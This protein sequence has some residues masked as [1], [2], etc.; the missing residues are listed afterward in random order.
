[1]L[2]L[3]LGLHAAVLI[4][5]QPRTVRVAMPETVID[6]RLVAPAPV[7]A[8]SP[9]P[10][11][12]PAR[13]PAVKPK[14]MLAKHPAPAV[15]PTPAPVIK[16]VPLPR[17]PAP[18][19]SSLATQA[20]VTEAPAQDAFPATTQPAVPAAKAD[21]AWYGARQ[22]DVQPRT[23]QPVEPVYPPEARRRN[24]EGSV[25]LKLRIDEFGN[26]KDVEVV[27]G[28]PPGVFDQSA[29]DAFQKAHFEPAIK[30]GRPV[31]ALVFIRVRYKL[32]DD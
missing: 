17:V 3:S 21:P 11:P 27:Q 20:P 28:V 14:P 9:T 10:A 6:A 24:Q 1:M 4:L 30:D 16:P 29:L 31:R 15:E 18:P 7:P 2:L 32:N 19:P 8:T 23:S 13:P 26:V 22:L 5:V 12:E 25:E